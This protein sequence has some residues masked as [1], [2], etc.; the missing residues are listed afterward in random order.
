MSSARDPRAEIHAANPWYVE[1][2]FAVQLGSPAFRAVVENRW[3]V[4]ERAIDE[5]T[6]LNGTVSPARLLDAGC[7]DGINLSF[8]AGMV[9]DRDW[10][11]MLVGADYNTL[12]IGRA[13][14]L[15]VSGLVRASVTSLA[16]GD[17]SFDVVVCNQVLEHVPEYQTGLDELRRVLRPGGLL[18]IGVPNEG[19]SLGILRNHVLQRSILRSTDHVNMFTKRMLLDRLHRAKLQVVRIEP[20]AFFVPHTAVHAWLN[21][22]HPVRRF[23]N[24]VGHLVP[25]CAAGLLAVA[26]RPR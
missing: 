21:R 18:L 17:C 9:R 4:F 25:S 12:R 7:G 26:K 15:R 2:Q 11:T 23:L 16:F 1:D 8:L 22:W 5:W 10:S 19:S 24:S 20:E 14:A 3:R 13:R 6:A